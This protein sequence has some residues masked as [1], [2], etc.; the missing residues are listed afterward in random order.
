MTLQE[1]KDKVAKSRG[2]NLWVDLTLD[3]KS[4]FGS[5]QIAIDEVAKLYAKE[6]LEEAAERAVV[7]YDGSPQTL[8]GSGTRFA[9]AVVDKKSI[10]ETPLD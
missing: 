1:I 10:T 5:Y 6:K 2:Y 8:D 7:K 3:R 4:D 9:L